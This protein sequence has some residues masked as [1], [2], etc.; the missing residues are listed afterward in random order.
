MVVRAGEFCG[1]EA[2]SFFRRDAV[3]AAAGHQHR[4]R[5]A[6]GI[7]GQVAGGANLVAFTTGRGSVFGC[8]P[9][10][11]LK[12][13]TNTPMFQ[14]MEEDMDINCGTILDGEATV[15]SMGQVIFEHM[16]EIASGKKSKSEELGLGDHEFVPWNIGVV[17]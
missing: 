9:A 14:R 1:D 16:L 7:F 2:A 6:L 8:K 13:A 12:L 15:A 4:A 11:S 17:S 10:P 3:F 5:I